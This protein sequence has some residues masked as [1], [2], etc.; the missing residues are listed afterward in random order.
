MIIITILVIQMQ[1]RNYSKKREAILAKIRSTMSHPTAEWVYHEL[2]SEIPDLSLA[3]VYRNIRLFKEEGEILSVGTVD[4]Q[5][6]F[7]GT[8]SPHGHFVC[9]ACAAV[10]DFADRTEHAEVWDH[11]R[12]QGFLVSRVDLVAYGTCEACLKTK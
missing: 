5:E 7:D 6:R 11:L 12:E 3:T 4:G 1:T 2:K 8:T 9:T 10:I